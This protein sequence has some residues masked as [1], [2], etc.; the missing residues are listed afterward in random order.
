MTMEKQGTGRV[1]GP[2]KVHPRNPRYFADGDG[3][4]VLLTGSHTWCNL[5]DYTYDAGSS[6][7]TFDFGAYLDFL[8]RHNHSF[9]RLWCWESVWNPD[10]KQSITRYDP[11]PYERTGPGAA[12]DGGPRFDLTRFHPP[13]FDRMRARIAA[14][15]D[16][17]FY[18]SVMLFNGVNVVSKGNLGGDP[19]RGHPFHPANNVNGVDGGDGDAI[20]RLADPGVLAHQEAYVRKVVDTVNALD[21][22]LYEVTNEDT[23]SDANTAWQYHV[24][25]FVQAYEATKPTQHPVGMTAQQPHT[26]DNRLYDSPA[27]WISTAARLPRGDGRKVIV[28]DTDHCF[29]WTYL[30]K[31][32]P[33][34]QR[35]W[36]W[37]N[38]TRGNQCLFMDPYLDAGHDPGRNFPAGDRTDP[39]WDTLRRAMG[40]TRACATRMDLAATAPHDDLASTGFCLARPG[41]EYL[42]YL[43][44]GREVTVDLSGSTSA[45]G[46]EWVHPVEGTRVSGEGV[47]GG[48]KR[49]FRSPFQE[50]AALVLRASGKGDMP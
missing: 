12:L 24:I 37:G 36:V 43:P 27:D 21:N 23:G 8:E 25:R 34:A 4:V 19:F 42:V 1:M 6:P 50:D 32:G 35:A 33:A 7:P 31:E 18:V 9:F 29:F 14:A 11:M 47:T 5:Q 41:A 48:G 45:F 16:R 28:N 15:R 46:V 26:D 17:G 30:K 22:V 20:R 2:L 3:K 39:Y 44:E 38:V 13:Y 40:V 10:A 49:V